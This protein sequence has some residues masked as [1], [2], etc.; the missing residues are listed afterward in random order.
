MS[1]GDTQQSTSQTNVDPAVSAMQKTLFDTGTGMLSGFFNNPSFAVEDFS[2]DQGAAFDLSRYAAKQASSPDNMIAPVS[3]DASK[4]TAAQ[5]DPSEIRGMLNPFMEDQIGQADRS[6][7]RNLNEQNAASDAA[8][9]ASSPLGGSGSVVARGIAGRN[10]LDTLG[11]TNAN[12]RSAGWQQAAGLAG[13]NAGFRQQAAMTNP[14]LA[15]QAAQTNNGL[16]NDQQTRLMKG[17]Q[18]LLQTG[19]LQQKQG[20]SILNVPTDALAKFNAITPKQVGTSTTST[21]PDNSPN[22][23]MQIFPMLLSAFL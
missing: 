7:M 2:P 6:I 14:T 1:K 11:S 12:M 18:G 8:S 22:P 15:L 19:D 13:Q 20:Q 10:A 3:G 16:L 5:L 17:I 23:L 9:A 21:T 4:V